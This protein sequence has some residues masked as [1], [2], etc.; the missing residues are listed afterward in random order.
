[1][2]KIVK[3]YLKSLELSSVNDLTDIQVEEY[4]TKYLQMPSSAHNAMKKVED[5]VFSIKE[6]HASMRTAMSTGQNFLCA[7]IEN[8]TYDGRYEPKKT[9]WI[10]EP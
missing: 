8:E 2:N 1:M 3:E 10:L 4:Y 9:G 5:G 7:F 6:V